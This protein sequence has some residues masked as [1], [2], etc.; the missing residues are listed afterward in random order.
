MIDS[1]QL[2]RYSRRRKGRP[3]TWLITDNKHAESRKESV[4]RS[5]IRSNDGKTGISLCL[6]IA[7]AII[8]RPKRL[9]AFASNAMDPNHTCDY[10]WN[11][12]YTSDNGAWEIVAANKQTL[13]TCY[14]CSPFPVIARIPIGQQERAM[15]R[16]EDGFLIAFSFL[17]FGG[18]DRKLVIDDSQE[19]INLLKI[20]LLLSVYH[21]CEGL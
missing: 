11:R 16:S 4:Y 5:I 6:T 12:D 18:Q 9:N 21:R 8:G 7:R 17:W 15:K 14:Y 3:K 19:R 13:T 2:N 10:T 1:L 20:A